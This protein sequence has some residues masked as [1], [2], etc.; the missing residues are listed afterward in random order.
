MAVA[1]GVTVV[2]VIA[3]APFFGIVGVA[4]GTAIGWFV[5]SVGFV[6]VYHRKDP[7]VWWRGI[8]SPTVRMSIAASL[9]TYAFYAAVHVSA[10][11]A[12]FV[13]RLVGF[14]L[15]GAI[16]AGYVL[17]FVLACMALGVWSQDRE[18]LASRFGELRARFGR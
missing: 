10:V 14:V 4:A 6:I 8:G 3:L 13:H 16:S 12:V 18:Q 9:A 5:S 11:Q 17:V 15:L 1:A 2:S 7:L